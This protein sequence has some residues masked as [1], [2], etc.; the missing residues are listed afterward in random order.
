MADC[1]N[2]SFK[3]YIEKQILLALS[4]RT[5]RLIKPNALLPVRGNTVRPI[6]FTYSEGIR[7]GMTMGWPSY[8]CR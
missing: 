1:E 7:E 5:N 2:G 4:L 3:Q 8:D 6:Q